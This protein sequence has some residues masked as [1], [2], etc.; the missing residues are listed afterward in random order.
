MHTYEVPLGVEVCLLRNA[1]RT[2]SLILVAAVLVVSEGFSCAQTA[3]DSNA[4]QA[5]TATPEHPITIKQLRTLLQELNNI[6]PTKQLTME[7]AE[8]QRK[9]LPPWFP[10][11]VWDTVEK[12]IMAIDIPLAELPVYQRYFSQE[13]ADAMI[14]A[15]QGRLGQ[16]L[17]E[18]FM[19]R[20]VTAAHSGT[21]GATTT[22]RALEETSNS[23]D[24]DVGAKRMNEL[25]PED[26]K[27]VLAAVQVMISAWKP[28]SDQL[29]VSY[30]DLI[31]NTI[32]KEIT[33]H[34][35]ELQT[36]QQA[37]LRNSSSHTSP[38]H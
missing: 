9:T 36:A 20:E 10:S 15:F 26:R 5:V 34:N 7:E 13:N 29:A 21:S 22:G 11:T 2:L 24:P 19:Q 18:H 3:S 38:Q 17:A 8:R 30:N 6:E 1:R 12:K 33:A 4:G 23:S 16:Q 35:Q 25:T 14:L 31:N 27:R 37:Y 28:I 32:Q